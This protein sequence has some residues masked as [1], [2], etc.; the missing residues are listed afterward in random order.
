MELEKV[1]IKIEFFKTFLLAFLTALF[2]MF[3]Y[4]V[5]NFKLL[6]LWQIYLTLFGIVTTLCIIAILLRLLKKEFK[7]LKDLK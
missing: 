5:V 7:C 1:K 6:A 3:A 2:G 4:I